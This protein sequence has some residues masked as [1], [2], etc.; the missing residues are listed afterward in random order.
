MSQSPSRAV[1]AGVVALVVVAL[2]W[3][4]RDVAMLAAFAALLAYALD[5]LV[6]AV[7]RIPLPRGDRFPRAGAAAIVMLTLVIVAVG[8]LS[9]VLP[10]LFAELSGF[11]LRTPENADRILGQL[12]T[13][14]GERGWA[15]RLDPVIEAARVSTLNWFQNLGGT[16]LGWTGSMFRGIGQVLGLAVLPVLAFY[17]LAEREAVQASVLRFAPESAHARLRK[18]MSAVDRALKSYVR[19]QALVCLIMGVVMGV[20]LFSMGFPV[21]LLLAVVVAVGEVLP[22]VGAAIVIIAI[23]VSGYGVSSGHAVLGVI[24]YAAVNQTIGLVVTPRV[25]GRHLKMHPFVV[26]VSV[27]AGF[28]LLGPAGAMVAL[29]GVA[30]IQ[31]VIEELAGKRRGPA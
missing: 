20:L 19:G 11:V 28:E 30:V 1:V 10:R 3:E 7:E 26:I 2:V 5:P 24:T 15:A 12:R 21:P 17:L 31:S 16:A 23:A 18:V 29:P 4:L 8:L 22:F 25:M 27:L 6:K 9:L 13:Y 14:A